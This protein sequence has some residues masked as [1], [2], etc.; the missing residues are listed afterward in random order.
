MLQE[1]FTAKN[2]AIVGVSKNPNKVGH[3]IFRN[4]IDTEF[5]GNISI[6]NPHEEAIL[7]YHSYKSILGIEDKIDLAI[8]AIPS[9]EIIKA[10]KDCI[11]KKIKNLIIISAGFKEVGNEK[12]ENELE[13]L[14]IKYKVNALGP[15]CLGILDTYSKIDTLFL[16]RYKMKRPKQGSIS[17]VS[18][19]GIVGCTLLDLM[20]DRGYGFSKFISYGNAAVI[21]ESD[22]L[23][24]LGNDPTT[25]VI[26]LYVEGIKDGRKFLE[27]AK[28]VSQ[29]K[30]IIAI[31]GG[32]TEQGAKATISHTGSLA[33][34]F[35]IYKGAFNQ[36]G[37]ITA[38]SLEDMFN[39]ARILEASIKPDGNKVQIIT[40]GGG[41]GVIS[42]D[43]LN[44]NNLIPAEMSKKTKDYLKK[45]MPPRVIISNPID[46]LG[47]A[48]THRYKHVIE[49]CMKDK[50]INIILLLVLYQ[51]PLLTTSIVDVITEFNDMKKKPI[52]VVSTG[53]EYTK[54]LKRNLEE[55][56]IPCFD[57]PG[58][59]VR[60][61][62][63]LTEFYKK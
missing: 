44:I 25:K 23:E 52:I 54:V 18:Q 56:N 2:I 26:C 28:K 53:G 45:I 6:V 62:K 46:L 57:Y 15:N 60:A 10:V 5:Q 33:G 63:K 13:K 7:T 29:K 1:F 59:A 37:I 40:N 11:K 58:Q 30:P 9:S 51:T 21:D 43:A 17:F 14:L 47:D 42:A 24:F 49:S 50:N 27:I 48:T 22:I 61:I 20:A 16:P 32:I 31:K 34:S 38:E 19:S 36:A 4:F 8:L 39:Y 12:L 41:Y 35:E 3:V 55:N